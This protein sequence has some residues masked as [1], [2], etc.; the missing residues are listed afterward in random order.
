MP[1]DPGTLTWS[2]GRAVWGK[3]G[4]VLSVVRF[5]LL[6]ASSSF[7]LSPSLDRLERRLLPRS[8]GA[9]L[10]VFWHSRSVVTCCCHSMSPGVSGCCVCSMALQSPQMPRNALFFVVGDFL[11]FKFQA[12]SRLARSVQF[13]FLSLRSS[14]LLR[15]IFVLS[16]PAVLPATPRLPTSRRIVGLVVRVAV[17]RTEC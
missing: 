15:T 3:N 17:P 1:G 11:C 12:Q 16:L 7:P 8:G 10:D 14:F 4:P 6:D 5:G 9:I 2:T 13:L